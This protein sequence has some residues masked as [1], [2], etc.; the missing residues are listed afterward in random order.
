MTTSSLT[1]SFCLLMNATRI[2]RLS[3][4]GRNYLTPA[5]VDVHHMEEWFH[6]EGDRTRVRDSYRICG[7]IER[8]GRDGGDRE[9]E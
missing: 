6:V 5:H 8:G 1:S 3:C 7:E 2:Y 9:I 4:C